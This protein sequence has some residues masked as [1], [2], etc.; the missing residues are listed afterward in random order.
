MVHLVQICIEK[1]INFDRMFE[2][3]KLA[4]AQLSSVIQSYPVQ[5]IKISNKKCAVWSAK[6]FSYINLFRWKK[7]I[8]FL[9]RIWTFSAK[10]MTLD[11]SLFCQI[12]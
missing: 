4:A 8:R 5:I 9:I 3:S 11:F 6:Y 1:R 10:W 7:I 12:N 2:D